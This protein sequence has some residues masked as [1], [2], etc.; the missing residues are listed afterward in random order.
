MNYY[1]KLII[2]SLVAN[3][4]IAGDPIRDSVKTSL[5][6]INAQSKRLEIIASNI[7]NSDTTGFTSG[8][9]PYQRKLVMFKTKK[10]KDIQKVKLAKIIMDKSDFIKK[11]EPYHPAA[12]NMGYVLYPNV[13]I[14]IETTDA[15]EAQRSYNANLNVI[16]IS[17]SIT[18]KTLDILG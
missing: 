4:A 3:I 14:L 10:D 5:S 17:R 2:L 7:A 15:K 12:D 11:Y 18:S 13:N 9:K 1:I 8:A 16:D 6:A